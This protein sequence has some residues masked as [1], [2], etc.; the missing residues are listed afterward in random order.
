[1]NSEMNR[2]ILCRSEEKE[3]LRCE[4]NLEQE[5]VLPDYCGDIKRILKCTVTP[6]IYSVS[7]S[8]Q[9]VTVRGEAVI[10]LVYADDKEKID[11]FEKTV[12]MSLGGQMTEECENPVVLATASADYVNCRAVNSRKVTVSSGVCVVCSVRGVG[13]KEILTCACEGTETKKVKCTEENLIC[14]GEKTFDMSETVVLD[15]S[16]PPVEKIIR[17]EAYV[18]IESR[19][20]VEG[21]LL[22]KGELIVKIIYC[23]SESENKLVRLIHK[24]PLSQIAD[25]EGLSRECNIRVSCKVNQLTVNPRS[26][27]SGAGKLLDVAARIG[28]FVTGSADK[29]YEYI[30]DCYSV[31]SAQEC[32]F[33][34]K[35]VLSCVYEG[36]RELS[37]SS[38]VNVSP[39]KEI[40]DVWVSEKGVRLTPS[41]DKVTATIKLN[42][43]VLGFDEKGCPVYRECETELESN[44]ELQKS[45][46]ELMCD[47]D[48]DVTDVRW[49]AVNKNET[50]ITALINAFIRI[51]SV[52]HIS[53]VNEIEIKDEKS[54]A[55]RPA[56][57]LY[58]CKKGEKVWDI[59]KKYCTTVSSLCCENGVS[60]DEITEDR[61]LMIPC[62]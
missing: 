8:G 51:Y 32:R 41:S 29:E 16:Q 36:K 58:Y 54:K 25:I 10:R 47:F 55:D 62:V 61:M 50:D 44:I 45:C 1:M 34:K 5:L 12:E 53:F 21:K 4:K 52:S 2:E 39:I 59:A 43:C 20:A 42:L 31:S 9:K 14:Q 17:Q 26:D 13:K 38:E 7:T 33:V 3:R 15:K 11:C 35:E 48:F 40:C 23:T 27:S 56:L 22:V 37:L 6:G 46:E 18:N 49:S 60:G 28:C 19:K 30:S 24:M 57:T